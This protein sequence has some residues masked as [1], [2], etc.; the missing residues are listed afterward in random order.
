MRRTS[1]EVRGVPDM[2]MVVTHIHPL[3]RFDLAMAILL[4]RRTLITEQDFGKLP[5]PEGYYLET[6]TAYYD[7]LARRIGEWMQGRTCPDEGWPLPV[8]KHGSMTFFA[9]D[10]K[11]RLVLS[12]SPRGWA[13]DT[14][15]QLAKPRDPWAMALRWVIGGQDRLPSQEIRRS[16][17]F[18]TRTLA[19][20]R[21]AGVDLQTLTALAALREGDSH[22]GMRAYFDA[23]QLMSDEADDDPLFARA[24]SSPLLRS[25][26]AA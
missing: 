13:L 17:D 26:L 5:Q 4:D 19:V 3:Q 16:R 9:N 14:F 18:F 21:M 24:V 15:G 6:A 7:L 11:F 8:V 20:L 25:V 10:K 1:Q 22:A 12:W 23:L 2:E